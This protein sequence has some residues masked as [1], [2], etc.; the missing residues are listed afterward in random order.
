MSRPFIREPGLIKRWRSGDR[1][2]AACISCDN[3]FEPIKKGEGVACI[4]SEPQEA[5]K[6]FPQLSEIVPASPP[7]PPGTGYKI[8]IGLEDWESNY[9]PI[10]KIQ[11]I[12]NE[13]TLERSLSFPLGTQDHQKVSRTIADLLEKH[14]NSNEQ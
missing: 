2:E 10:V 11:M 8:S 6:F 4:P 14:A 13:R 1:R 9:I 3:C 12:Y 7:H 5:Q